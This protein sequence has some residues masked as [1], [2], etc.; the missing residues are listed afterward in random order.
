MPFNCM[1]SL[2]VLDRFDPHKR[3]SLKGMLYAS[4]QSANEVCK[5]LEKLGLVRC[6]WWEA[7]DAM[8][9]SMYVWEQV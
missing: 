1:F 8:Y 4:Y 9:E 7:H 2:S 5:H 3:R 6:V